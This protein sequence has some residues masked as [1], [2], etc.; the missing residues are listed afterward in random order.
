MY[1][2]SG[3]IVER[4][5][6]HLCGPVE[7]AQGWQIIN[8]P[9][10]SC[11]GCRLDY[12]RQWADRLTMESLSFPKDEQ[13]FVTLTYDDANLVFVGDRPTLCKG[14]LQKF[15][16]DLRNSY[17]SDRLRFYACGEYGG[18]TLRP[19]YHLLLFGLH[20]DDL[21]LYKLNF[22]HDPL[23]NSQ[24]L[25][26]VWKK[27]HVVVGEVNWQTCAYTAR[28]VMKKAK[29]KGEKLA[30][31]SVGILPE[32][33]VMS[34]RPG[35]GVQYFRD[36]QEQIERDGRI[37]LPSRDF[38]RSCG[39]PRLFMDYLV[40]EKP[41]VAEALADRARTVSELSYKEHLSQMPSLDEDEY[42]ANER[43]L[44]EQRVRGLVRGL[45]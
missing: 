39:I 6:Y 38:P 10:G 19:H 34:R 9:C 22:N 14:H 25:S 7:S 16:K 18:Q 11:V 31:E 36:N 8:V 26:D 15:M 4:K 1:D 28:Y 23:Y 42:F 27:G 45:R 5:V 17:R 33:V 44:T 29:S 24:Q 41:T 21:K 30:Y 35:I 43:V 40:Q 32:F 12:S 20:L 37:Y 2:E 13:Y 3:K